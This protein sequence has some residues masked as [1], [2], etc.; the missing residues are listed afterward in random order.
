MNVQEKIKLLTRKGVFPY[1]YVKN[2]EVRNE[3]SLPPRE[4]FYNRLSGSECS[5]ADYSHAQNVYNTFGLRTLKE[6]LELYLFADVCQLADVFESYRE[7]CISSYKLD[8]VYFLSAPQLAWNALLQYIKRAIEL[9]YDAEM[10]RMI[11]PAIRGG[12]CHASVR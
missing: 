4:A 6:Y 1:D 5:P 9:M 7:T 2:M 3:T 8:P 10:Y 11:Q 12:I